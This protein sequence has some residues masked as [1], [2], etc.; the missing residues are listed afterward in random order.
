V[1]DRPE[2]PRDG[3]AFLAAILV[4]ATLVV[5]MTACGSSAPHDEL[6]TG[7]GGSGAAGASGSSIAATSSSGAGFVCAAPEPPFQAEPVY[8]D[9][10]TA[11][12]LTADETPAVGALAHVCG[13]DDCSPAVSADDQGFASVSV[14]GTYGGPRFVYGDGEAFSELA[15]ALEPPEAAPAFGVIHTIAL[16]P[17]GT[18]VALVAG[19]DATSNG[20]VL[21]V[22][23]GA[24]VRHDPFRAIDPATLGFRAT[25][26]LTES[27]AIPAVQSA[28]LAIE[29]WLDSRRTRV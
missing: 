8:I 11:T 15:V 6:P 24:S 2:L 26:V 28:G 3:I 20:V 4:S 10:V 27:M 5:S 21:R 25:A 22:P 9:T 12:I 29:C 14:Q 7:S 23:S 17:P 19:Q 18:G 16:P 1:H 13:T